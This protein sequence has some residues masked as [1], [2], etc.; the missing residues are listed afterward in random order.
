[1]KK[2]SAALF[3]AL[4]LGTA[5]LIPIQASAQ[6][7][8]NVNIGAEP[9]PPRYERVPG[10]RKGY[11]WAPGYWNWN[12][13]GH[14]WVPGYWVKARSGYVYEKAHWYQDRGGWHLR[15]GHWK[16]DRHHHGHKPKKHDRGH[17]YHCPPGQA[18][19]G[20]C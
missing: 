3:T 2:T 12:G 4:L 13:H 7:S 8:I 5:T 11:V 9:P 15:K 18:K 19:K 6:V 20:H 10:P 17:G 1:M 16:E 14:V